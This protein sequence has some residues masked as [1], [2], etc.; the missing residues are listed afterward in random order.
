MSHIFFCNLDSFF[1]KFKMP[2]SILKLFI[3]EKMIQK[4]KKKLAEIHH[5]CKL[6]FTKLSTDYPQIIK[7]L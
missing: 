1:S 3:L 4:P 6:L 7:S 5:P 2:R